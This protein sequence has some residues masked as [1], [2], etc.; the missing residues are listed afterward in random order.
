[1]SMNTAMPAALRKEDSFSAG[2][3]KRAAL[4]SRP[5]RAGSGEEPAAREFSISLSF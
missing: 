3:R 5:G 2:P 1:M 4:S